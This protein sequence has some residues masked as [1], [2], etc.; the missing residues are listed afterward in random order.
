MNIDREQLQLPHIPDKAEDDAMLL[1]RI[2]AE[3]NG[4]MAMLQSTVERQGA[5]LQDLTSLVESFA[6]KLAEQKS[7]NASRGYKA[8]QAA[9]ARAAGLSVEDFIAMAGDTDTCPPCLHKTKRKAFRET[10]ERWGKGKR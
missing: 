5:A 2:I 8:R 9:A 1:S 10:H 3:M 7:A 6:P 4:R